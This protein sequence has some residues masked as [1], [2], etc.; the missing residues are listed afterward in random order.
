M[1]NIKED[2]MAGG[3]SVGGGMIAGIGAPSSDPNAPA[4][5]KEPGVKKKKKTVMTTDPLARKGV[6]SFGEWFTLQRN[7]NVVRSSD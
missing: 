1:K 5:F 3:T 4:N 6:K 2:G 7:K